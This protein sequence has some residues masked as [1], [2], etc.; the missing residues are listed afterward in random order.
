ML[1]RIEVK[2]KLLTI[3]FFFI[4]KR[5]EEFHDVILGKQRASQ[6]SHD[7]HDWS[8]NPEVVFNDSNETVCNDGDMNLNTYCIVTLSPKGLDSEMLLNPFEEQFDLP[9]VFIKK[10]DVF[11]NKIEVVR[12]VSE[13]TVKFRC[14]VNNTPDFTR[15]FL[16]VLLLREDNGLI[17]QN[18]VRSVNNVFTIDDFVTWPFFLTNDEECSRYGNFVKSGEVKVASVKDIASQWLV[19]KPIH[20]VDIVHISI[21]D[22]IEYRNFC[23]NVHL[24]VDFDSRFRTSELRPFKERHAEV[25]GGRVHGVESTVQFKLSC[26]PSLLRKGYHVKGKLLKYTIVP[27]VVSLGKSTLVDS[28]LPESEMKR[29]LGMGDCYICKFSQSMATHKLTAHENEKMTPMRRGPVLGPVVEFDHKAFEVSLW[30]KADYLSEN[31]LSDMHICPNFD[32]GAKVCISKVRQ[33][34]SDLSYCA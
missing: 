11:G 14:V 25:N 29:F 6:D 32:L 22:S 13:R 31:V 27:E 26:N 17:E 1:I 10:G 28:C 15:I 4:V 19:C 18:I 20:G 2:F 16:L 12:V 34:F 21:G 5:G 9:P 23:N 3:A 8:S 24:G 30:K 33:T 7:L